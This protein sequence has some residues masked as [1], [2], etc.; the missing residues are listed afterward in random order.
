MSKGNSKEKEKLVAGPKWVLDSSTSIK[1][2]TVNRLATSFTL[3]HPPR[4]LAEMR[5]VCVNETADVIEIQNSVN[6]NKAFREPLSKC[7][8]RSTDGRA[9]RG[10]VPGTIH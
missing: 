8:I 2:T 5:K 1:T 4:L 9:L 6:L 7:A 3:P 10:Y